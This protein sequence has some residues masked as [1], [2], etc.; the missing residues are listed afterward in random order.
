MQTA[1]VGLIGSNAMVMRSADDSCP[2]IMLS[3]S[4]LPSELRAARV[5]DNTADDRHRGGLPSRQRDTDPLRSDARTLAA[6]AGDPTHLLQGVTNFGLGHDEQTPERIDDLNAFH[7]NRGR[8]TSILQ[9][10]LP[11]DGCVNSKTDPAEQNTQWE[12]HPLTLHGSLA[13]GDIRKGEVT[14]QNYL[15]NCRWFN[16]YGKAYNLKQFRL[17]LS[18]TH[19]SDLC[20]Y[21]SYQACITG[22]KKNFYLHDFSKQ[23]FG[24]P[25]K[26]STLQ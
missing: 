8:E 6:I 17:N 1:M 18:T 12:A 14:I 7:R 2:N 23:Q 15:R 4:F 5:I 21:A 20:E 26:L 25:W 3:Q 9:K 22:S 24:E 11:H 13:E 16:E 10:R 19:A